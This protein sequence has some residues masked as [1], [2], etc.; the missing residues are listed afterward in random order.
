ML[1]ADR[2]PQQTLGRTEVRRL[3]RSAMLDGAFS[4]S[5]AAGPSD[6]TKPRGC[7]DRLFASATDQERKQPAELLHLLPGNVVARV[8]LESGIKG[9]LHRWMPAQKFANPHGIF[10]LP[11]PPQPH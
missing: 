3:N 4:T 1:N 7:A 2:K 8:R 6:N 5:Q 10:C 11:T 9:F